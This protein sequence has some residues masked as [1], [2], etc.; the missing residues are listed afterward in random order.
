MPT[1]KSRWPLRHLSIRV[2]W[3]DDGWRGVVCKAPSHNMDCLR[4]KRIAK[5]RDDEAEDRIA[6][7][8]IAHLS[9]SEWPA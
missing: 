8:S 9:P 2:P 3:H 4:L 6:G 7:R 5:S 1:E